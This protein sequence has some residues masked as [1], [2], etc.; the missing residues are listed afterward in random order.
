M[1]VT[2]GVAI[3]QSIVMKG[4][5]D[6]FYERMNITRRW[7]LQLHVNCKYVNHSLTNSA[8]MLEPLVGFVVVSTVSYKITKTKV[9]V[10]I[11][12]MYIQYGF[13]KLN[14]S[15]VITHPFVK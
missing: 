7:F 3:F 11:C 4:R 1:V 2:V 8:S 15:I 5:W 14:S 12:G 9:A 6:L 10:N 13:V